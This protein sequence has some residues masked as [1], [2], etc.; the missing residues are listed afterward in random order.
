[1]ETKE[2]PDK[3]MLDICAIVAAPVMRRN[4]KEKL[5][6]YPDNVIRDQ[7]DPGNKVPPRKTVGTIDPKGIS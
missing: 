7:Q 3:P 2:D 4:K 1:M 5:K 6:V